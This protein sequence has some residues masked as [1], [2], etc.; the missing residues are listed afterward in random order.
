MNE[1][2]IEDLRKTLRA[3]LKGEARASVAK[4]ARQYDEF[5]LE[6]E[7]VPVDAW[8]VLLEVFR[9]RKVL[10][11]SGLENFLLELN[12]DQ[13]KYSA[14]QLLE[15]LRL[16]ESG[17]AD[18]EHEIARHAAGDFIARAYPPEIA[19]KTLSRMAAANARERH[20]ALVG[21]DVLRHHAYPE[22]VSAISDLTRAL[23]ASE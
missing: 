11:Q 13:S 23:L 4:L 12:V 6:F 15:L 19:F 1:V 2:S 17:A 20:V 8:N 10:Q 18:M 3:I 22:M 5:I 9:E 7:Q 21:L 14:E 16:L